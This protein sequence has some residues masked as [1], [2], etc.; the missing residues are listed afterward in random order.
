MVLL[1][2][3][4]LSS[5]ELQSPIS[6]LFFQCLSCCIL[7]AMLSA[8]NLICLE[9]WCGPTAHLD[10][11]YCVL[12]KMCREYCF[13]TNACYCMLLHATMQELGDSSTVAA[14]ECDFRGNDLVVLFCSEESRRSHGH[15]PKKYDQCVHNLWRLRFIWEGVAFSSLSLL[16]ARSCRKCQLQPST[17]YLVFSYPWWYQT[18]QSRR[19]SGY[20]LTYCHANRHSAY[21]HLFTQAICSSYRCM[22]QVSGHH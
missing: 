12:D 9:P 22:G 7:V 1:N 20:F 6:L 17:A 18:T 3:A 16:L 13:L 4:A 14:C 10:R 5:W 21:H 15:C 2:K 11:M 19:D 8:M